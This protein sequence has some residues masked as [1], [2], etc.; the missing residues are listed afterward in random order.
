MSHI[1]WLMDHTLYSPLEIKNNS[2]TFQWFLR[3]PSVFE[4]HLVIIADKT[5]EFQELLKKRIESFRKELQTYWEQVQEYETWGDIKQLAK[6]KRK[7]TI[8]DARL[9]AAMDLID[10]INEEEAAFGWDLSQY[11]IR[12][13]AHDFLKPFKILFDASQEF[14]DKH[15]LWMHSQVGSFDAD[16]IDND[17]STI[18][19]IVQ[20]VEKQQS[21]RP[22]TLELIQD[23]RNVFICNI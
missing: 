12:K 13:K 18:H 11:P 4:E 21:D 7:A 19:R 10:R 5:I 15:D 17:V 22:H 1:L 3:L 20:K 9:V 2:N 8:L 23:V 6:Y 16:E 14:M